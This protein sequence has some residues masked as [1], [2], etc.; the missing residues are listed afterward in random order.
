MEGKWKELAN[1]SLPVLV[2]H[3]LVLVDSLLMNTEQPHH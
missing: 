1:K 3:S 2:P